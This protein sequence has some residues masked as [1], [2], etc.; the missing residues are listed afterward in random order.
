[1]TG[2][3]PIKTCM[4]HECIVPTAEW[5]LRKSEKTLA[6]YLK[7]GGS[8]ATHIVG[9]WDLGHYAPELWPTARGFDGFFGL[10]Q[11][12]YLDYSTHSVGQ[13]GVA[14][15]GDVY[16]LAL[17]NASVGVERVA[18]A[19][20]EY[21]TSL[22]SDA[23]VARVARFDARDRARRLFLALAYN[24]IHP[25]VSVPDGL[26][27]DAE[28]VALNA[29]LAAARA[30]RARRE[31]AG[32]L[33][34]VDRGVGAL[35]D[36][37]RD[38]GRMWDETVLVVV[39]D[40]GAQVASGGSNWPLRGEK[41]TAWE[42]GHRVPAFVCSPNARWVPASRRGAAYARPFTAADW[43]PSLVS[44]VL[45]AAWASPPGATAADGVDL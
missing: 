12:G 33:L 35:V 20:G 37:L 17:G 19:A 15:G 28:F 38:N 8:Y 4:Q 18:A 2:K 23:A 32:A 7:K 40:N 13:N 27:A 39:S 24:A 11:E 1:M 3:Y 26:R 25:V 34:L 29:S 44:G 22:F 14:G 30:P 16:D 9:K 36:A 43:A 42:G 6:N 21:A 10:V 31:L 41:A 5:G 45:G